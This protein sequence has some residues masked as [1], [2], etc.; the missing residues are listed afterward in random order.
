M[1][2]TFKTVQNKIL[3]IP[4]TCVSWNF[5]FCPNI[6]NIW[7]YNLCNMTTCRFWTRNFARR[8]FS[9]DRQSLFMFCA[10]FSNVIIQNVSVSVIFIRNFF[11]ILS[12]TFDFFSSGNPKKFLFFICNTIFEVSRKRN[13]FS[14]NGILIDPSFIPLLPHVYR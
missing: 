7:K 10:T 1:I 11:L 12:P 3:N 13:L 6:C 8:E 4:K 2:Y 14:T 5:K 9:L